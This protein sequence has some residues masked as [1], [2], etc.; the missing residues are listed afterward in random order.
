MYSID[1]ND[2]TDT[3]EGFI[4]GPAFAFKEQHRSAIVP[5]SI[6]KNYILKMKVDALLSVRKLVL[7]LPYYCTRA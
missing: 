3:P 2:F 7:V 1:M 6:V 4:F 5:V